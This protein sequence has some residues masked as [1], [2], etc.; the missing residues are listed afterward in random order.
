MKKILLCLI[1]ISIILSSLSFGN[2]FASD[3]AKNLY[4]NESFEN[5]PTH[6][7]PDGAVVSGETGTL[8]IDV[9]DTDKALCIP[10]MMG[11]GTIEFPF[12]PDS[13]EYVITMDI[14][15][16]SDLAAG[17]DISVANADSKFSFVTSDTDGSLKTHNGKYIGGISANRAF[18]LAIFVNTAPKRYSVTVNNIGVASNIKCDALPLNPDSLILQS[19]SLEGGGLII[20][21]LASYNGRTIRSNLPSKPYNTQKFEYT[22]P[23][24]KS[25]IIIHDHYN[26]KYPKFSL[27]NYDDINKVH[28]GVNT[29]DDR[30]MIMESV[31][32]GA[33]NINYIDTEVLNQ[34]RYMTFEFD[35]KIPKAGSGSMALRDSE[36][37]WSYLLQVNEK[38]EVTFT[39]TG[40]VI[41]EVNANTWTRLRYRYDF[42]NKTVS[43]WVNGKQLY[44]NTPMHNASKLIWDLRYFRISQTGNDVTQFA[45]DNLRIY[46]GKEIMDESVFEKDAL[47]LKTVFPDNDEDALELLKE[48]TAFNTA[49]DSVFFN[50]QKKEFGIK[51][52]VENGKVYVGEGICSEVFGEIPEINDTISNDGVT[53]LS[54]EALAAAKKICYNFYPDY[55][56]VLITNYAVGDYTEEE[57]GLMSYYVLY[58]RPDVQK[59]L[60]DFNTLNP[61]NDHP[62]LIARAEDFERVKENAKKSELVK[63]WVDTLIGYADSNLTSEPPL[64]KEGDNMLA[65]ARSGLKVVE[66]CS[67][68]YRLTGDK[69]YTDRIWK[70]VKTHGDWAKWSPIDQDLATAENSAM[71]AIAYDWCYEVWT[72]EQK[73][74]ME[75][76]MQT[77]GIDA[78]SS[79]YYTDGRSFANVKTNW[80]PV[81]NGGVA[82][83]SL[84]MLEKNPEYYAN[85]VATAIRSSEH[86][87]RVSFAPEGN[88]SEGPNYWDYA[89]RYSVKF[90]G[91][92][93]STLGDDYGILGSKGLNM[94]A[95][96]MVD[97]DSSVDVN[98]YHDSEPGHHNGSMFTWLADVYNDDTVMQLKLVRDELL[99]TDPEVYD[100]IF[101]KDLS[102]TADD[103]KLPLDS[104]Y[105]GKEQL[106][107]MRSGW[108]TGAELFVSTHSGVTKGSHM[109]YDS[110][111]F[112][113]YANGE[114]WAMDI[115][116]SALSYTANAVRENIYNIRA[117]GHN[118]I[119][120]DPDESPGIEKE[121][122][123]NVEKF[124]T[125]SRGA[126]E[127][128]NLTDAYPGKVNSYRR[129]LMLDDNRR[130][131][132]IRDELDLNGEHEVYWFM[133]TPAKV[134]IIDKNTAILTKNNKQMKMHIACDAADYEFVPMPAVLLDTSPDQYKGEQDIDYSYITRLAIKFKASGKVNIEARMINVGDPAESNPLKNIPMDQWTIPDGDVPV[135]PTLDMLYLDSQ[136]IEGFKPSKTL[137]AF[138]ASPEEF[139]GHTVEAVAEGKVVEKTYNEITGNWSVK[140]YDASTPDNYNLY[141]VIFNVVDPY[142]TV[143]MYHRYVPAELTASDI[144]QPENPPEFVTDDN[145]SSRWAAEGDG[146]W[147]LQDLGEEK[148]IDAF[149]MGFHLSDQRIYTYKLEYSTDGVNYTTY[150][151]D[152][153]TMTEGYILLR[154]DKPIKAR[155]VRFIG[156]GNSRND[157]NSVTE[158]G[159]LARK[160]G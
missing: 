106:V 44:D 66:E 135:P 117:E 10:A 105:S 24:I 92:L 59:I 25:E 88:Y 129:G 138:N 94:T 87:Y 71:T 80:N 158:F 122:V 153:S 65:E 142:D 39:P 112:V 159:V 109:H 95:K 64:W 56:L 83:A 98:N 17:L 60:A 1:S 30:Y 68:A 18:T 76:K 52:I 108:Y 58:D 124:E 53:Y 47:E 141:S 107:N 119:V 22:K 121:S 81:C 72:D 100:P 48:K 31:G 110:G 51:P 74:Y 42:V 32:Q 34:N 11:G 33:F 49:S 113:F 148:T 152:K 120:I 137:Y 118:V 93:N 84:A 102:I 127:I 114:K 155:Y 73:S 77:Y 5:Y 79:D 9:T 145:L 35:F 115:G 8:V 160:E 133:H 143:E 104:Y 67:F 111:S 78:L 150:F 116:R 29:G 23:V 37:T 55:D 91:S 96:F 46:T 61:D 97:T 3:D 7:V 28:Y 125:K 157:W 16:E 20:D 85:L 14:K 103:I 154:C 26:G 99:G 19:K 140:V 27:T 75:E 40:Y 13:K 139:L 21:N 41:N 57:L 136:P 126:F 131:L 128:T 15:S 43:F 6:T 151:D 149:A 130:S 147:L 54:L 63:K 144:P 2:V 70:E 69:K 36:N 45:Y 82:L 89:A 4:L 90:I 50:G 101:Y 86:I 134:E 62:R 156:Y 146:H 12:A 132:V 123:L 38:G